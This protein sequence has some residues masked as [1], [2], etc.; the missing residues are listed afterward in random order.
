MGSLQE[1][2]CMS[3]GM[4]VKFQ[5]KVLAFF[6]HPEHRKYVELVDEGCFDTPELKLGYE[7]IRAYVKEFGE[8]PDVVNA[9][10]YLAQTPAV[11]RMR[12]DVQQEMIAYV[13][14]V[15]SNRVAKE[16]GLVLKSITDYAARKRSIEIVKKNMDKIKEGGLAEVKKL[17]A[18]IGKVA[19]IDRSLLELES[20]HGGFLIDDHYRKVIEIM[21]GAPCFLKQ[22]NRLTA[23]GG[24]KSPELVIIMSAPK[25]FKT[26]LCLNMA[27]N[28]MRAGKRVY[29]ADFEN[30]VKS[31]AIRS[32]QLLMESTREELMDPANMETLGQVMKQI[33]RLGG[34]MNVNYYTAYKDTVHDVE[35]HLVELYNANGWRP[36]IIVW[37]YP[38]VMAPIERQ[39]E[40]RKNISRVYFDIIDL[41]NRLGCFSFGVSQV[42]R[43]AVD[44]PVFTITDFAEDFAKAAN[45]HSAWALCRTDE[46]VL[47]GIGRILPV[48]QREGSRYKG[49][50]VC[51]VRIDEERMMIEEITVEQATELVSAFVKP[52]KEVPRARKR[53]TDLR[54]E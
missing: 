12:P 37:D 34:D 19:T 33:K 40:D 49:N 27:V 54:D 15:F 41:N 35:Q 32:L 25:G 46:E 2:G 42:N 52:G 3:V 23:A 5:A 24:F 4:T 20:G 16:D 39:K 17:Y 11:Q 45:C 7:V 6:C 14:R 8:V 9:V 44:K 50:N 48:A 28:Y 26:G 21:P 13:E 38:D 47:A 51:H 18:E 31:I 53:H 1:L 10:E 22:V 43:N 29:Y 36:D 30:G